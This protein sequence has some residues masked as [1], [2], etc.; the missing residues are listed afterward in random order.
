MQTAVVALVVVAVDTTWA[1]E[2]CDVKKGKLQHCLR[3]GINNMKMII[4]EIKNKKKVDEQTVN[5]VIIYSHKL[6]IKSEDLR[7]LIYMN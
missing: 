1:G 5:Q 3:H 6:R 7:S 2:K 4:M